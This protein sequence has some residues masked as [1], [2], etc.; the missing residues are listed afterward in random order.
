MQTHTHFLC[1][2]AITKARKHTTPISQ[3]NAVPRDS[4]HI[5]ANMTKH[6]RKAHQVNPCYQE[7]VPNSGLTFK[8]NA[9][10]LNGADNVNREGEK[11]MQVYDV[12][13]IPGVVDS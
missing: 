5:D 4:P 10:H 2:L 3:H 9:W 13:K 8:K 11:E 12:S 1:T 6:R 7:S